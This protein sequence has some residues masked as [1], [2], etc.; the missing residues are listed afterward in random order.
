[1]KAISIRKVGIGDG[2]QFTS[3]PENYFRMT[4]EKL[5]DVSRPWYLDYNPYVDRER[6]GAPENITELWN[7]PKQYEWPKLRESGVYVSNAEI[8][9]AV[10]GVRNPILIRPRLYHYEDY[11]FQKR[12]TILVHAHGISQGS[13]PAHVLKH[14]LAKYGPTGHLFQIG[15]PTD[16]WIGIPRLDT[17]TLWC[18]AQAISQCRMLIG[19]DSGPTWIGACYPDVIVK[20]I[21]TIFQKGYVEEPKNWVPLDSRN[22]HSF[23]DDRLFQIYNVT[24]DDVGFTMSYRKL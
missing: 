16:P 19:V 1:M 7:F 9:A 11:S 12:D 18:L 23:W 6:E 3:L 20:K 10:M 17:P 13:L 21:R 2:V 24:E 15:L 14:I 8:H 5:I 4:G 22:H